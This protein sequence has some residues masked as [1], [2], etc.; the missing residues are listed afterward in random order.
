MRKVFIA[1]TFMLML[2]ASIPGATLLSFAEETSDGPSIIDFQVASFEAEYCLYLKIK[3]EDAASGIDR[4]MVEGIQYGDDTPQGWRT[5]LAYIHFDGRKRIDDIYR[6]QLP[7]LSPG[8]IRIT[9]IIITNK[10]GKETEYTGEDFHLDTFTRVPDGELKFQWLGDKNLAKNLKTVPEGKVVEVTINTDS[11]EMGNYP[12]NLEDLLEKP[13][14]D[15]ILTKQALDAIKGKDIMLV[16]NANGFQWIINGKDIVNK[17]KDLNMFAFFSDPDSNGRNTDNLMVKYA[18]N[19]TLPCKAVFR[20]QKSYYESV[21][22]D[23]NRKVT[24][25]NLFYLTGGKAQYE[26]KCYVDAMSDSPWIYIDLTHNSTF[27]VSPHK[28]IDNINIGKIKLSKT[29]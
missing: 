23:T 24:D 4:I 2:I 22:E 15:V 16:I 6:V 11:P 1:I 25:L 9:N 12:G 26:G 20:F 27:L 21:T 5:G 28:K 29:S 17:T 13:L 10:A 8:E 3:A 14:K 18:D 19:G 7:P